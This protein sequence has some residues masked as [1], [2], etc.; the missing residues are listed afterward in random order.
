MSKRDR[1]GVR[2][3]ADIERKYNLGGFIKEQ[4]RSSQL[5]DSELGILRVNQNQLELTTEEK[6]ELL[7]EVDAS[8]EQSLTEFKEKTDNKVNQLNEAIQS[9]AETIESTN[10]NVSKNAT[11][12]ETNKTNI[13]N[14][15]SD[16]NSS[17]WFAR[18]VMTGDQ[19]I[20]T[21]STYQAVPLKTLSQNGDF[22]TLSSDGKTLTFTKKMV[23]T[24]SA[25]LYYYTGFTVDS[26]N[27]ANID[28]NGSTLIRSQGR[29]NTTSPYQTVAT[30]SIPITVNVGDTIGLSA[31]SSA[32]GGIV[33]AY[34]FSSLLIVDVKGVL[35]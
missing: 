23:V 14:L 11:A 28:L 12:I 33:K 18:L 27:Y 13:S 17:L 31:Y 19:T 10:E 15:Q 5:Q 35:D 25:Q 22:F 20:S 3:P 34:N 2:L 21:A 6:I 29:L 8:L 16:V 7:E 26:S 32:K 4:R 24:I 9:N 30:P 1:Q